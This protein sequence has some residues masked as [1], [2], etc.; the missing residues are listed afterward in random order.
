M[1]LGFAALFFC[2]AAGATELSDFSGK[3]TLVKSEA[4]KKDRRTGTVIVTQKGDLIQIGLA[5]SDKRGSYW[6]TNTYPL[7]GR[8]VVYTS[9]DGAKGKGRAEFAG[10]YLIVRTVV[11]ARAEPS[12]PP[13]EIRRAL[14]LELSK[15]SRTLTIR[16]AT[17][18]PNMPFLDMSEIEK[19]ARE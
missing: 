8:E 11:V 4:P 1:V 9:P 15:D 17:D 18:F 5:W 13:V 6:E 14:R 19:Y 7:D 2:S 10:K 12:R 16:T 3:Y